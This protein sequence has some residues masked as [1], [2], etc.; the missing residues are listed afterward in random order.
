M[1]IRRDFVTNSS[2]SSF[3]VS[4][5]NAMTS[6][7]KDEFIDY[8][9]QTIFGNECITSIENLEKFLTEYDIPLDSKVA[10]QLKL[11]LKSDRIIHIGSIDY[12]DCDNMYY[13]YKDILNKLIELNPD[14]VGYSEIDE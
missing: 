6:D 10:K 4:L 5:K 3:I 14:N 8:V 2:S 11:D 1:K 13:M 9:F 7:Q 12:D